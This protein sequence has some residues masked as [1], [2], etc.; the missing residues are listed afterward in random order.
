MAK[1]EGGRKD[2]SNKVCAED[3]YA[4]SIQPGGE[5]LPITILEEEGFCDKWVGL[6]EAA[7]RQCPTK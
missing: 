1:K 5:G 6:I 4:K 3:R 7:S 2:K